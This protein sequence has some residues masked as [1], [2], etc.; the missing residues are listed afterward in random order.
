MPIGSRLTQE[1]RTMS[2]TCLPRRVSQC[3][4]VLGPCFHHRHHL[5]FSWVLVLHLVDGERANL[6]ALAR[7][8]PAHL[9][10]QHYRCLLRAEISEGRDIHFT[11]PDDPQTACV[12][13]HRAGGRIGRPDE[14]VEAVV[15]LFFEAKWQ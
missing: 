6:K 13:P 15:W 8:G 4:R 2:L 10:Y 7:H 12:P 9:A 1:A 5:V 3:L 14:I 11:P